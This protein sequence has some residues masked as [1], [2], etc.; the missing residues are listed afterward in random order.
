MKRLV[1]LT[2]SAWL[3]CFAL[4]LEVQFQSVRVQVIDRGQVDGI[5]IRT[6]NAQWVVIDAGTNRE[7]ADAM[8]NTG[9]WIG[10]HS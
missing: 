5:L 9:V 6:P 8:E 3:L 4:P 1:V 7:Q 10:L 2:A